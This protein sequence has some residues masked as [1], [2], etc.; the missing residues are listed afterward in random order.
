M[1]TQPFGCSLGTAASLWG[2]PHPSSALHPVTFVPCHASWCLMFFSPQSA[3][4]TIV[5]FFLVDD[6]SQYEPS[7]PFVSHVSVSQ[8]TLASL[9]EAD[10][11]HFTL[12]IPPG[13]GLT[14]FHALCSS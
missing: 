3:Y 9:V 11:L 7:A 12:V 5:R 10:D 8:A 1:A 4:F 13:C 6:Y 14:C 2:K